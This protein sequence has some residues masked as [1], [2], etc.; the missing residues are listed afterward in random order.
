MLSLRYIF[1]IAA[2]CLGY[3]ALSQSPG[4][5]AISTSQG[6]SQGMVFAMLQDREGFI[7]VATKNGL[8]RYDGYSFNVFTNDPYNKNSLS[9][10]T[11]TALFEDRQGGYGQAQITPV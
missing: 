2:A 3:I 6:L 1:A 7:W 8:N 4:Y 10:N 5:E 9:S 11:V